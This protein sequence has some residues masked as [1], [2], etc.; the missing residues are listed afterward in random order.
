M[1]DNLLVFFSWC[2]RAAVA[3]VQH[4]CAL[5]DLDECAA[6]DGRLRRLRPTAMTARYPSPTRKH[7]YDTWHWHA[8]NG[9]SGGEEHT[10][11]ASAALAIIG[12]T[13]SS[14]RHTSP[15]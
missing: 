1:A 15:A 14:A 11:S 9:D 4:T 10:V 13:V 2:Q 6:Y 5:T 8:K 12:T 7:V 3:G